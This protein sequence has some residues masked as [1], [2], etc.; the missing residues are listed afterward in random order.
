MA[1][2]DNLKAARTR[3]GMSQE[4]V[5][6]R[7]GI[8]RQAVTKWEAGQS[9]PSARNLQALAELY[10]IP[11]EELLAD[12]QPKGPNLILRG[13]LT[14]IAICAHA[15]FLHLCAHVLY[16]LRHP[17]PGSADLDFY[18][19][20][21][22]GVFIFSLVLTFLAGVWMASNHRYKPDQA[23]RRKNVRI[24]MVYCCIQTIVGLL[25]IY[26]GMGWMGPILIIVVYIVYILYI[27]PKFMNRK[28]TR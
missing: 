10:Q 23:R 12:V 4:L 17:E 14:R 9:R 15:V 13:N 5:A 22:R 28:L 6:E 20:F 27:N 2:S 21:N 7:L 11:S 1:L 19:S 3:V 18:L 24:E 26:F 8:S 16:K 25:I